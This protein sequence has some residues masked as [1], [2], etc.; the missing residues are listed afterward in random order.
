MRLPA[1]AEGA[2]VAPQQVV[3]HAENVEA[4]HSVQ[5]D[6]LGECERSVAPRGVRVKL[7]KQHPGLHACSVAPPLP[8]RGEKAV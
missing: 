1:K 3:G 6:E 5:V 2:I 8:L 7:A 4:V